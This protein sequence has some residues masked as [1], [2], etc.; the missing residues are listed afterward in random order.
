MLTNNSPD[1]MFVNYQT[2][3]HDDFDSIEDFNYDVFRILD[4]MGLL[5]IESIEE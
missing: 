5:R 3:E 4:T 2:L 1:N